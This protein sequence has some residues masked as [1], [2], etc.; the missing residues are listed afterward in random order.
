M[1]LTAI[2]LRDLR[3]RARAVGRKN[4]GKQPRII[5]IAE[6]RFDRLIIEGVV[7]KPPDDFVPGARRAVKQPIF[8]CNHPV[9][10]IDC[11]E[12]YEFLSGSWI[13][14]A[15]FGGIDRGG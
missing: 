15:G 14:Q 10:F 7:A 12:V 2:L 5:E 6:V 4:F 13:P 1:W 8:S 9:V 11:D 3:R